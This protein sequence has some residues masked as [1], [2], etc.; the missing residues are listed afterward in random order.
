VLSVRDP[1]ARLAY[2]G[3][4]Q[5]RGLLGL[6]HKEI[7]GLVRDAV[8]PAARPRTV[9][10]SPEMGAEL[11]S[12]R[13]RLLELDWRDAEDGVYPR[14][15]LF[16]APWLRWASVYPLL[17]LDLPSVWSRRIRRDWRDLPAGIDPDAFPSYYLQNFHHQSDGYL[18]GRSAALYDLQVEILFNGAAD[19]MRRRILRPLVEGL[20]PFAD[21]PAGT[22]RVLDVGTGSGRTLRQLRGALPQAQLVGLD[23]STAYLRQAL[24]DLATS[25]GELP[26]LVQGNAENLPFADGSVQAV[27]CVFLLHELPGPARRRVIE[28]AFR[29][30]EG[31]GVFLLADSAQLADSPQFSAAMENFHRT[32]HEPFYRDYIGDDIEARLVAAGFELVSAATHMLTRV[33]TARKPH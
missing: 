23:L 17:W 12:A 26:Q 10:V 20:R 3:L 30:L 32:F 11:Q 2:T 19:P 27:T 33:W 9:P 7:S 31:G 16:E 21:R 8:A 29:V 4:Q 5:G 24:D 25:P 6:A 13:E 1:L 28:E 14:E 22:L 18:S 15:L